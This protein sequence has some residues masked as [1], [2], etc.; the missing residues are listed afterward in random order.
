MSF[1]LSG[2]RKSF[3]RP[4][5][6]VHE[7][8]HVPAMAGAKGEHLC[9]VGGSGS[10]K[11]TLLNVIAGITLP[12]AG[13]VVVDGT[14]ITALREPARDRFRARHVG[15]VFQ[16]FNLL[17]GYS[18][19]EN[20]LLPL[21]FAGVRGRAATDRAAGLL[22]RVGLGAKRANKPSALSVGEQQRVA[23]ARA[24]AC[25]PSLLLADEPTANLD[26]ANAN[27]AIA[28]LKEVAAEAGAGLV[29]VTHDDRIRDQFTRVEVLGSAA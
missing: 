15:Y 26:A 1:E 17:Q 23:L 12:D 22:E 4:G 5:G 14:D 20:V 7:A 19:L 21:H 9:I 3:P 24:V 16:V 8:L 27:H 13:R 29:V 6:G 18:A 11:T 2:I 25:R 10:G 28:L